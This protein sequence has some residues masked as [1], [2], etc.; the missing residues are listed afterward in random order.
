M[1]KYHPR[2]KKHSRTS[3]I[4]SGVT[5][6]RGIKRTAHHHSECFAFTLTA[7]K[8]ELRIP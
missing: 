6:G 3:T 5:F 4:I 8:A 2:N 1:M 7:R